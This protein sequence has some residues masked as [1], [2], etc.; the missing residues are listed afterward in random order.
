MRLTNINFEQM[1]NYHN[2]SKAVMTIGVRSYEIKI[3]FGVIKSKNSYIESID[4]KPKKTSK[5]ASQLETNYSSS[6]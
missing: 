2:I 5:F 4:E 3:P 6:N 1:L